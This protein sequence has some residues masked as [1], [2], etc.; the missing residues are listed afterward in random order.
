M[1][2]NA[3]G[4]LWYGPEWV[5]EQRLQVVDEDRFTVAR[6]VEGQFRKLPV[7]VRLVERFDVAWPTYLVY[8]IAPQGGLEAGATFRVS[9]ER[10]LQFADRLGLETIPS[11][12]QRV[13]TVDREALPA[14]TEF[15]LQVGAVSAGPVSVAGSASC[16]EWLDGIEVRVSGWLPPAAQRWA[17]QLMYRTTIGDGDRW[18]SQTSMCSF[19]APG[20]S[21]EGLGRERIVAVCEEPTEPPLA[22]VL[23]PG[24]HELTMEAYLPG[25]DVV[26][27]TPVESMELRCPVHESPSLGGA[28]GPLCLQ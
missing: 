5:L 7:E 17:D 18:L 8:V 27:R 14:D 22:R 26:L 1:P 3:A 11:N 23:K 9:D 24:R 12:A 4:I 6:L 2:A 28:T 10:V 19:P 20:R 25:T 21:V 13:V 16:T 15:S